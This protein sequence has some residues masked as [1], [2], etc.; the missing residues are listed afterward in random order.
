MRRCAASHVSSPNL[1]S[2]TSLPTDAS[3]DIGVGTGPLEAVSA[4][5]KGQSV[6]TILDVVGEVVATVVTGLVVSDGLTTLLDVADRG[7]QSENGAG[8]SEQDGLQGRH[9]E[10]DVEKVNDVVLIG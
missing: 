7:C 9:G 5:S 2:G 10:K 8:R 6:G 4:S 3:N 1:P